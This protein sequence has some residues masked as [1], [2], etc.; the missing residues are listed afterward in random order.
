MRDETYEERARR[1][2]LPLQWKIFKGING[3]FGAMRMRLMRA[4]TN[5]D[6]KKLEGVIFFEMAPAIGKNEYGWKDDKLKMTIALTVND[7]AKLLQF[8]NK[9]T[10]PVFKDKKQQG[11][12]YTCS[13]YHD[14]GAGS[15]YAG[16]VVTS[17]TLS[18]S[19]QKTDLFLKMYQREHDV[20]KEATVPVS[21]SEAITMKLL[22]EAAIPTMLAWCPPP[23][24]Q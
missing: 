11:E 24:S 7:T 12:F 19:P 8:L 21:G 18:Y 2:H 3:K 6:P 1:E 20:K 23:A 10:H 4:W 5:T 14:R 16:Q 9:P 15:Q 13:I 17:V 22:F